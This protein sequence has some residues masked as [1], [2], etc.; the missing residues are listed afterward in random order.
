MV[1]R[2]T[3]RRAWCGGYSSFDSHVSF[4]TS[5]GVGLDETYEAL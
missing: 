1:Y 4:Y 3:N 5:K 2:L